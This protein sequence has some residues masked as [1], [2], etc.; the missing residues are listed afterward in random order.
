MTE[1][2]DIS[3]IEIRMCLSCVTVFPLK[4]DRAFTKPLT[5]K[6]FVMPPSTVYYFPQYS[7]N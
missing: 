4:Q 5:R 7:L 1:L 6:H 3:N 2:E